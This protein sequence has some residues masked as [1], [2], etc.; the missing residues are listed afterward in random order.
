MFK[1]KTLFWVTIIL[2]IAL[3]CR[4]FLFI[5]ILLKNPVFFLTDTDG[6][7][8]IADN[9]V[10]HSF[11]SADNIRPEDNRTPLY[12]FFIALFKWIGLS[13]AGVVFVQTLLSSATCLLV[14]LIAYNLLNSWLP[15]CLAGGIVAVDIPSVVFAN[16][17]L[18]ETLFTFVITLSILYLVLYF[19]RHERISLLFISSSFTGLS[20][21]CRPISA[22]FPFVTIAFIFLFSKMP[23]I[24]VFRRILLYLVICFIV[25]APWLIR[26]KIVFGYPFLSTVS[27][28][29]FLTDRASG[30][31]AVMEGI[32]FAEAEQILLKRAESTFQGDTEKDY[33]NY[34]RFEGKMGV[35]IVLDHPFIYV[36]NTVVSMFNILFKPIR[37]TI[38]LQLG[39]KEK[40][41][42]LTPWGKKGELS[43]LSRLLK[44]TS[45]F[46][47]IFV[48]I[49]L[50]M[51]IILWAS[52]AYGIVISFIKKDYLSFCIVTLIIAYF[53][54]ISAGPVAYARHR[55]PILPFLAIGGGIG[56]AGAYER[57][58]GITI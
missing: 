34:K 7:L 43:L 47:I 42:T 23:K 28:H 17:L 2:V 27:W 32:S 8:N 1:D 38:D 55:V 52:F 9:L 56:M 13:N 58:K 22:Y 57:L 33:I 18:T 53:S 51:L 20:I 21:L 26:N 24:Y 46:T 31:Y 35:S 37:S 3:A 10:N 11:F 6:Y 41:T 39:F 54:I 29:N 40:G 30:V 14:I 50:L 15:A 49:Q 44:M 12:P 36:R 16:C 5:G 19:K 25:I 45:N 4:I 48:V